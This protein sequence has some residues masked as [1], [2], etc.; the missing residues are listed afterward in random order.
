ME[1]T[2]TTTTIE[3][4]AFWKMHYQQFLLS[5]LSKTAYAQRHQ[6]VKHRVGYW[7]RKF[8]AVAKA[9]LNSQDGFIPVTIKKPTLPVSDKNV[10]VLCTLQ[11]G[12]NKQLLVHSELALKLC[13]ESWR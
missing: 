2:T 5:N 7:F 1:S 12:D 3:N 10:L 6:L 8:E 11:L 9:S 13:L 4:K